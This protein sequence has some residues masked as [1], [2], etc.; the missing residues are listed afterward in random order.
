MNNNSNQTGSLI[1]LALVLGITVYALMFFGN[2]IE[3]KN[4]TSSFGQLNTKASSGLFSKNNTSSDV[5]VSELKNQTDLSINI[6]SYKMG[7]TSGGDYAQS[8]SLGFM[9]NEVNQVD[10]QN[11]NS[12]NAS[13]KTTSS[14]TNHVNYQSLA[15]GNANVEYI[16]NS[17]NPT[18][19]DV[20]IMLILDSRSAQAAMSS[21]QGSKRATASLAAKTATASTDVNGKKVLKRAPG[22][23]IDPSAGGSLPIGNGVWILL[24]LLGIYTSKKL[25]F[26]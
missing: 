14:V 5:S 7:S 17:R 10:V 22:D 16:S 13:S 20:N 19:S 1:L 9:S 21:Q 12:I 11:S 23:P 6:P 2:N 24:S 8:T 26:K 18:Q 4:N 15:I 25:I 3:Q